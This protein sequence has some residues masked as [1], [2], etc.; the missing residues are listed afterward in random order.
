MTMNHLL[1]AAA[2]L[3][4]FGDQED[5][6]ATNDFGGQQEVVPQRPQGQLTRRNVVRFEPLPD[7]SG[8]RQ[9]RR[10]RAPTPPLI[11][12]GEPT[13]PTT[14]TPKHGSSPILYIELTVTILIM[15]IISRNGP[16]LVSAAESSIKSTPHNGTMHLTD[17]G[18]VVFSTKTAILHLEV[19]PYLLYNKIKDSL[20]NFASTS[21]LTNR[22]R[23]SQ[24]PF[25]QQILLSELER[26]SFILNEFAESLNNLSGIVTNRSKRIAEWI[27]LGLSIFN[28]GW[29]AYLSTQVFENSRT[30]TNLKIAV[31]HLQQTVILQD[32]RIQLLADSMLQFQ[33][34]V[35]EATE[36]N[37]VT[38]I[39]HGISDQVHQYS[40]E[41]NEG[42]HRHRIPYTLF[43]PSDINNAWANLTAELDKQNL[44]PIFSNKPSQL[45]ELEADYYIL[46]GT[47]HI[48]IKVPIRENTQST[49]RLKQ[50]L[51]TILYIKNSIFL[52]EDNS[53]MAIP[54]DTTSSPV[55]TVIEQDEMKECIAY[56]N[57]YCCPKRI[58][59]FNKRP[60]S[61][62]LL[63][64][65]TLPSRACMS[66]F[67]L[68]DPKLSYV[69]SKPQNLFD[70]YVPGVESGTMNCPK[71][72]P[73]SF[74]LS[75][76]Q[77][78]QIPPG[79]TLSTTSY[80]LVST[81]NFQFL[82]AINADFHSTV[83]LASLLLRLPEVESAIK[84][85]LD[86]LTTALKAE[87]LTLQDLL[88]NNNNNS[89]IVYASIV[90][91]IIILIILILLVYCVKRRRNRTPNPSAPLEINTLPMRSVS[92]QPMAHAA[93]LIEFNTRK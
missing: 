87:P 27:G 57:T 55:P 3:F 21:T 34:G 14:S 72:P 5:H 91:S 92:P 82:P 54:S 85:A 1:K 25:M 6:Q 9:R 2:W 66:K 73:H 68:L 17:R 64:P 61:H 8:L 50:A 37:A 45:Y 38:K 74:T 89:T 35:Y 70:L 31:G 20:Q 58:F 10:A 71:T 84:N 33:A 36:M 52:Y 63:D 77:E 28:T 43:S 67:T 62:Q 83:D 88:D 44:C 26:T 81:E 15:L 65:Y 16:F 76:L 49:L 60:C 32:H 24:A 90:A 12:L 11:D 4:G 93:R 40:K 13:S 7:A 41:L 18:N 48:L 39:L 42:I 47:F 53:F 75:Y 19:D 46:N 78:I 86:P 80:R 56:G 29:S 22:E 79:C 23:P 59:S 30:N 51:P 69:V